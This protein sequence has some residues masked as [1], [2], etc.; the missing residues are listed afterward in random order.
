[1]RKNN[2]ETIDAI[3]LCHILEEFAVF[4]S[5]L[6]AALEGESINSNFIINLNKISHGEKCFGALKAKRFYLDNKSVIDIINMHTSIYNFIANNYDHKGTIKRDALWNLYMYLKHHQEDLDAILAVLYKIR[7]LGLVRLH[8]GQKLDFS[9][10]TYSVN[11]YFNSNPSIVYLDNM[12]AKPSYRSDIIEYTTIDSPYR[13]ILDTHFLRV[14]PSEWNEIEVNTLIFDPSRLP[15]VINQEE[16]CDKII[17]LGS[18]KQKEYQAIR[19]SVNLGVGIADLYALFT[20]V[21]G[22]IES[23]ANVEQKEKLIA[24]CF[25][26]KETMEK[27][28]AL[29][30]E[31]DKSIEST[32]DIS[33]EV[34]D[35]EKEAYVRRREASKID[36]C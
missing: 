14:H 9:A 13:I 18:T 34:L 30:A 2:I 4:N 8:F 27:M 12:E 15:R 19:N 16:T 36:L 5:N 35:S 3:T 23:L 10:E 29:G 21:H 31:Y 22:K 24:L 20:K 33:Q 28:Q 25:E 26:I 1:M 6:N 11:L 7:D 17:A 32:L